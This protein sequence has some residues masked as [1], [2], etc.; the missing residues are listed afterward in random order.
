MSQDFDSDVLDLVKQKGFYPYEYMSSFET[1]IERLSSKEK[2][3]N[4]LMYWKIRDK[5]YEHV[6]KVW[7]RFG[8]KTMKGYQDLH[9]NCVI[10]WLADV[11]EK[12]I[13]SSLKNYELCSNHYLSVPALNWDAILNKTN[14]EPELISY[15]LYT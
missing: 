9:L 6:L 14:V 8:M 10:S 13:N 5:E 2:F 11:Y 3:Y 7:Y 15:A 4:S 1:F 12:I